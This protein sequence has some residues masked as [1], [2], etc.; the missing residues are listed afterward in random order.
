MSEL[1]GIETRK[2]EKIHYTQLK[3][4]EE[5]K[6]AGKISGITLDLKFISK[7]PGFL[8]DIFKEA[9]KTLKDAPGDLLGLHYYIAVLKKLPLEKVEEMER[10]TQK[11]LKKRRELKRQRLDAGNIEKAVKEVES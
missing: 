2:L 6:K 9:D 7:N 3:I 11:E 4:I 8:R 5:R 1:S 10:D